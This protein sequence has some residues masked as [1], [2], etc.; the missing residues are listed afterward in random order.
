M[1]C[2][3]HS[4]KKLANCAILFTYTCYSRRFQKY[5][6]FY[7]SLR[8]PTSLLRSRQHLTLK[9]KPQRAFHA[10]PT[11]CLKEDG[12]RSGNELEG[13]KQEQIDKQKRGEG[14]WHEEL[15]SSGESNVK[16]DKEKVHDHDEH[17]EDLQK[18]TANK[19]EKGDL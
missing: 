4:H 11:I 14:H 18:H 17:M 1:Q 3:T 16:A 10:T 9:V 5:Q 6:T 15:A 13:K 2:I 12:D 19:S 7:M 8:F